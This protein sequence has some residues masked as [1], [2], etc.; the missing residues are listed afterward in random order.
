MNDAKTMI[1][2]PDNAAE[3]LTYWS[4]CLGKTLI[5]S[6]SQSQRPYTVGLNNRYK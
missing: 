2:A 3:Y 1:V 5:Q 6:H 4:L